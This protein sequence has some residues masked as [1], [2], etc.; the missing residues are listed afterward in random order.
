MRRRRRWL[1]Q[2]PRVRIAFNSSD[3]LTHTVTGGVHDDDDDEE[4]Y[5]CWWGSIPFGLRRRRTLIPAMS[6][7]VVG[8]TS[9]RWHVLGFVRSFFF[10]WFFDYVAILF[11]GAHC[12]ALRTR[13]PCWKFSTFLQRFSHSGMPC[14]GW[15]RIF[16]F[17]C[18]IGAVGDVW[19]SCCK[20]II[21]LISR[22][23][24]CCK[25]CIPVNALEARWSRL[26]PT[27]VIFYLH[28]LTTS[29]DY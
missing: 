2:W 18:A 16:S 26:G 6:F 15:W 29:T 10:R 28:L 24:S 4:I 3:T 13:P 25:Q 19:W 27:D 22:K 7:S 8:L 9:Q 23:V 20:A 21:G 1:R 11:Y 5:A 14:Y 12:V 17:I